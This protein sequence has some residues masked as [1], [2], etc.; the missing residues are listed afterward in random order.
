MTTKLRRRCQRLIDSVIDRYGNRGSVIAELKPRGVRL[1]GPG[2]RRS[3]FI[4]WERIARAAEVQPNLPGSFADNP[5]GWLLRLDKMPATGSRN[6]K[7]V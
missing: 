2:T 7:E 3:L 6:G 5:L 1:R 4:T